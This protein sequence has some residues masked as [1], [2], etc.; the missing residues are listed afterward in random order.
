M[1]RRTFL[2]SAGVTA[3][4]ILIR[5]S[6]AFAAGG[7]G[8]GTPSGPL[9]F[10]AGQTVNVTGKYFNGSSGI[11]ANGCANVVITNCDFADGNGISLNNLT[12]SL[13]VQNNRLRNPGLNAITLQNSIVHGLVW[14]NA[15]RGHGPSTVDYIRIVNTGGLGSTDPLLLKVN[16]NHIDGRDPVT[17]ATNILANGGSGIFYGGITSGTIQ[18][19]DIESNTVFNAAQYGLHVDSGG[20]ST[21]P[22]VL[23]YNGLY[24]EKNPNSVAA[25]YLSKGA[26]TV[27]GYTSVSVHDLY[28]LNSAGT[29]VPYLDD[30]TLTTNYVSNVM[31]AVDLNATG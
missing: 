16:D 17:G 25:I 28:W 31:L 4:G 19:V 8:S 11:T 23:Y 30:H 21:T 13:T 6:L 2:Y 22:I 9:N 20:S 27:G 3:A 7:F 1:D 5:P 29:L 14:K 10:T 26:G 24:S 12:G 15:I 18:Y